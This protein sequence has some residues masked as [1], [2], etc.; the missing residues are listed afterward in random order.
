MSTEGKVM[1][2][3]FRIETRCVCGSQFDIQG[4]YAFERIER[5]WLIWLK[6]HANCVRNEQAYRM[7]I[8][9]DTGAING[10]VEL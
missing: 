9:L 5:L 6:L 3:N 10:K 8:F 4:Q 2:S 1:E 7:P